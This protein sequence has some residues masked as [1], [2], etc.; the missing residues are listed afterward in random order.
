MPSDLGIDEVLQHVQSTISTKQNLDLLKPYMKD[1]IFAALNQMHPCKAP[2]PDGMHA[3]FYQKFWHI[4]GDDVTSFVSDIL[5]GYSSLDLV[6]RTNIALIPKVNEPKT[7]AEFRPISL[8]NVLYKLVSKALVMRLK[9]ILPGIVSENQSAFVPGRLITDNA[10]IAMELFHTMKKRSKG[11]KG[12]IALKLDMSKAYDR[13]EW[14]FLHDSILFARS[15]RRECEAIVDILNKYEVASGQKINYEKSEVSF[16]K[17][18]RQGQRDELMSV[19]N[20]RQVDRHEKYLGIPT[21]VGRSKKAI[22]A[23]ILDR[24]WKKLQGWKEKLLSRAGKEVLLKAVI[25]AIP[26]YLMGVYKFPCS[27]VEKIGSAMARFFWGQKGMRR[28][29]HWR[30]W[31]AMCTPKCLGGMGFRDLSVFNDALLGRQAW[32]LVFKDGSLLSKVMKAKYYPN[33]DFLDASL[34]YAGSYSWRSIWS[35]KSLVKEGVIWRIGNGSTVNVWRDP[36]VADELGRFIT[37][38]PCEGINQVSDLIDFSR[39]EWNEDLISAHFNERDQKCILTIP[40]SLREPKDLLTWAFSNDGLYSTKTA[41]M[42][43]KGCNMDDF[44]RVWR[45]IWGLEVTPKV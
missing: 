36:W 20:M 30:S 35:S 19:L 38:K 8:C 29:V 42:L 15:N 24:M 10:L 41:Y 21:V 25:Q 6:N 39:F 9:L 14:G 4:V 28:K 3:I 16:S 33:C 37:S 34:G 26:T 1:E 7:T 17:G 44:H 2:G 18:V 43:G 32:R 31:A 5:H 27:V 11:R 23:A 45:T 40:L 22:F 13:V 12:T